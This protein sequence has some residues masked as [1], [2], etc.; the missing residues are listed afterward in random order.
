M[1]C[2]LCVC[3]YISVGESFRQRSYILHNITLDAFR[4]EPT[5]E[6]SSNQGNTL[7]NKSASKFSSNDANIEEPFLVPQR[8]IQSK[9]L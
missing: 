4:Q 6:R 1:A 7:E 9:I 2:Y 3:L 5:F 8:I